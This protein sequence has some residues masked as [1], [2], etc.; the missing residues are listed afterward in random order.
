MTVIDWNALMRESAAAVAVVP[1]G[2]YDM[3]II[4]AEHVTSSTGKPMYKVSLRV[5]SGPHQGRT[6]INNFVVSPDSPN[7]LRM[8]FKQMAAFGLDS[9]FFAQNPAP[10]IVAQSLVNRRARVTI[11]HKTWNNELRNEINGV[12]PIPAGAGGA[13]PVTLAA[14]PLGV[15]VPGGIVGAATPMSDPYQQA[16]VTQVPQ[17]QVPQPLAPQQTPGPTQFTPEQIAMM[18]A[19]LAAQVQPAPTPQ[20][21]PESQPQPVPEPQPQVQA[22]P[23]DTVLSQFTPE[24]LALIQAQIAQQAATQQVAQAP[25]PA[26]APVTTPV[27]EPPIAPVI[28]LP[29]QPQPQVEPQQPTAAPPLPY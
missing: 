1:D 19:Q 23:Q 21:V 3:S 7:A 4:K 13:V 9:T 11:G 10:D 15:Q 16:T 22:P 17:V 18:Q 5:D 26:P 8:F 14:A 27:A 29:V 12:N 2:D 25:Q 20:P 28:Q 6:L 24:Q